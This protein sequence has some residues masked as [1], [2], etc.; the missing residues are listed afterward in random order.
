MNQSHNCINAPSKWLTRV[1]QWL[2]KRCSTFAFPMTKSFNTKLE[3]V[4]MQFSISIFRQFALT[5]IGTKSVTVPPGLSYPR[6]KVNI[7]GRRCLLVLYILELANKYKM[8]PIFQPMA[9]CGGIARLPVTPMPQVQNLNA[10]DQ[11]GQKMAV[12][13][14]SD[15]RNPMLASIELNGVNF[16][17]SHQVW[18]GATPAET[19]FWCIKSFPMKVKHPFICSTPER[20]SCAVPSLFTVCAD[21]GFSADAALANAAG[22]GKLDVPILVV[23]QEDGLLYPTALSFTYSLHRWSA[24]WLWIVIFLSHICLLSLMQNPLPM[25]NQSQSELVPAEKFDV[26]SSGHLKINNGVANNNR[27]MNIVIS[28]IIVCLLIL[29]IPSLRKWQQHWAVKERQQITESSDVTITFTT[30]PLFCL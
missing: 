4:C 27:W 6:T 21:L 26:N 14:L 22:N 5:P 8:L 15:A 3:R 7:A 16:S 23:R 30:F 24:E 1:G 9:G 2:A 25:K 19:L 11:N 28:H 29:Q 10:L 12:A 18:F 17:P 13:N 20:L